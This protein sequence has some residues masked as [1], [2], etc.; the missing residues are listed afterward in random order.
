MTARKNREV[1]D[2]SRDELARVVERV[3]DALYRDEQDGTLDPDKPW[4]GDTI[5]VIAQVLIDVGLRPE[6]VPGEPDGTNDED[7]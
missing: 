6:A 3:R 2:L 1:S 5:E 7:G 4:D